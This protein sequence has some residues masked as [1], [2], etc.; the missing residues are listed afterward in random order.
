MMCAYYPA[1]RLIPCASEDEIK[2]KYIDPSLM[3]NSLLCARV[4]VAEVTRYSAVN[5]QNMLDKLL[6]GGHITP[7][8]YISRLPAGLLMDRRALIED[9]EKRTNDK[10]KEDTYEE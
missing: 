9:I 1:D 2:A 4:D 5:A 10:R 3:R 7:T 8:E 6:D